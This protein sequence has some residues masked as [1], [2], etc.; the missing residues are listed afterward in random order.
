MKLPA[1]FDK[2]LLGVVSA[3]LVV[4][5]LY[6][7]FQVSQTRFFDIDEFTHLNWA[8]SI[9]RGE[10]PY[11][12]F[13]TFF[14]PGFHWIFSLLFFINT[15]DSMVFLQARYLAFVIFLGNTVLIGV[16]FALL[17]R[18]LF[19][20]LSMIFFAWLP[21]PY[22]KLLEIRPDN[23]ALFF[24]LLGLVIQAFL[25]RNSTRYSKQLFV[26]AG[27]AYA[28]ATIVLVKMIPF[29]GIGVLLFLVHPA[30]WSYLRSIV[31]T[32]RVQLREFTETP[33][34]GLVGFAAVMLL[35][36]LWLLTLGN[37][38]L[39]WYS[40]T[41]LAFEANKA[42]SHYIMEPHLFFFPN[43]SFYGPGTINAGLIGNHA[44]W[45]VGILV[46]VIRLCTP[47][48]AS[49]G[50]KQLG[51]IEIGMAGIFFAFSFLYIEYYILKHIQYLIPVSVF[52]AW[53]AADGIS[54]VYTSARR[55]VVR[56]IVFTAL[57][58]GG[59]GLVVTA[60]TVNAPKL[61][62]NNSIQLQQIDTLIAMIPPESEVF[63]VEGRLLFWKP[64]Y[65]I[66]CL[67]FMTYIQHLSWPIEPLVQVLERKK[68]PYIYQGDT[69]RLPYMTSEELQYI[70]TN[71]TPVEGWGDT[72]WKRKQGE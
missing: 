2:Y 40:L 12:D 7:R 5:L 20:P 4:V 13:F 48:I 35:F 10:K 39:V 67:P 68:V 65:Y 51:F 49:R 66:C 18:K 15:P 53:Y 31:Q 33:L 32:R 61:L 55:S 70:R 25:A 30:S 1:S 24:C 26:A 59:Y 19:A 58:A 11:I 37:I 36:C 43:S 8:A 16:L 60:Q 46:G 52:V 23:L 9:A 29:I 45:F 21:M 47:F 6:W 38:P 22:D 71:Y 42:F 34:L 44:I 56:V 27:V 3:L 69:G 63:D 62:G 64:A 50:N 41:G 57:L 72:L 54:W 14:T 28:I 17:R